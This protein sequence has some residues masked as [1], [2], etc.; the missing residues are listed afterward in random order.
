MEIIYLETSS[1]VGKLSL[2]TRPLFMFNVIF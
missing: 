1:I 2:I